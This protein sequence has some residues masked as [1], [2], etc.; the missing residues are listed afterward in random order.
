MARIILIT[1]GSR[2]GKSEYARRLAEGVPG[3]RTFIATAVAMDVEMR[4]RIRKHREARS[5]TD[6]KL[7][8]E[9]LEL[10]RAI[11]SSEES[12]VILVDCLTLWINNLMHEAGE[13]TVTPREIAGTN[14][15]GDTKREEARSTMR[16]NSHLQQPDRDAESGNV[17]S[18]NKGSRDISSI[19]EEI[20]STRCE[21]V[22]EAC[23]R[24]R[25][26]VVFVANEVGMGIVPDNSASRLFR[27]LAGRCNQVMAA[28]ADEVTLVVCGLPVYVKRAHS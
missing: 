18:I 21:E 9:P 2:S 1:G 12:A 14:V 23:R 13:N 24:N 17:S 6:W 5:K 25:G 11:R 28:A 7:L 4:E 16:I 20:I 15:C 22:I 27:D 3:Q 10:V 26:T 8:E 19:T